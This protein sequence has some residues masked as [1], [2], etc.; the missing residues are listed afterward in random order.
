MSSIAI[1]GNASGA[2]VFTIAS[3]NSASSFTATLP[4]ATTTLVGTDATQ[5]LTNKTI[6]GGAITS[7]TAAAASSG[8]AVLFTSIPSWV[9][10]ITVLFNEVSLSG[11]DNILVQLGD[12]GG[13]ETTGYISSSVNTTGAGGNT[14]SSTTG[15]IVASTLAAYINSGALV[16]TSMGTNLWIASGAGKLSTGVG[17][18]SGGSKTLSDTLTQL[19]IT[20]TGANTFDGAGTVNI[21][22]E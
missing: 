5:T 13:L 20:V 22:Y 8:T 10:R 11:T 21:L 14:V 18:F 6:Q 17:W 4:A 3:P 9:K 12:A 2:G 15:F 19:N 1:T 7:S 16:L